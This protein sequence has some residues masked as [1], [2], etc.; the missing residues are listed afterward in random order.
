MKSR[1][2]AI[3]V[4]TCV[5]AG[6]V[7]CTS[8]GAYSAEKVIELSYSNH[9]PPEFGISKV[10]EEWAREIEKRTNGRVKFT[11]YHGGT[12]TSS[13]KCYEGAVKG[14][15]DIGHSVL[16]Y[17]QGRFPLMDVIDLPGYPIF[18]AQITSRIADDVY[19]KF[20]PKELSDVHVLYIHCFM[21]GIIYTRNKP[22]NRLEDLKG[23][24]IRSAGMATRLMKHLGA[25]PVGMPKADEYDAMQRGVV[26]GTVGAP[27]SLKGWRIA[28]V[29]KY[30]TWVPRAGYTNAQFVVMNKKK[31]ES[32]PK[33]IQKII[34]EVNEEYLGKTAE[35]WNTIDVEAVEY[36]KKMGHQFI[37]PDEK[38]AARWD[39]AVKPM[40]DEYLKNTESK[41]L[42]GKAALEYRQQLMEKYSK[43]YKP[44]FK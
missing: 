23:L 12:L 36:G 20:Q 29:S 34:T 15:S 16:A 28:E 27:A 42:P 43:I 22:V 6:I 21:P 14:L 39:A 5:I 1:R 3:L 9:H 44:I 19:R 18:N 24:R 32:L 10:D 35:G 37:H 31:W 7:F 33:D 4:A 30:S 11:F 40:F 2:F 17:T 41:G 38:E 8:T 26:D 13:S 25:T